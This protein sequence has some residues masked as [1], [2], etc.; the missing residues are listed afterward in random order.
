MIN[1]SFV[2]W[3]RM[4]RNRPGTKKQTGGMAQARATKRRGEKEIDAVIPNQ[5]YIMCTDQQG[6]TEKFI[7]L[8]SN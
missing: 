2:G 6:N 8:S 3:L 1:Y 7:T 4:L 5:F